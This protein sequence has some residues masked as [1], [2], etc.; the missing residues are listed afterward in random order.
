MTPR[1]VLLFTKDFGEEDILAAPDQPFGEPVAPDI[2]RGKE[3][4]TV[5]IFLTA[6][7]LD[8]GMSPDIS[9]YGQAY[10]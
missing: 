7:I 3:R 2:F 4:D 6:Y 9:H 1:K 5:H 8:H 10:W